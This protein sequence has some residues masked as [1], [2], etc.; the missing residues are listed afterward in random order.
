[1]KMAQRSIRTAG[2]YGI[3]VNPFEIGAIGPAGKRLRQ[4]GPDAVFFVQ[5]E[6]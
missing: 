6:A 5:L 1:M 3:F 2:L 4:T